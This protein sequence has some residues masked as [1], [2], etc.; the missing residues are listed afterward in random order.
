MGDERPTGATPGTGSR[1]RV[2]GAA[3]REPPAEALRERQLGQLVAATRQASGH[4]GVIPQPLPARRTVATATASLLAGLPLAT[5]GLATAGVSLPQP[6]VSAFRAVGIELPNQAQDGDR[7]R[8]VRGGERRDRSRQAGSE[9]TREGAGSP[10][11]G[12]DARPGAMPTPSRGQPSPDGPPAGTPGGKPQGTPGG[13]QQGS[14][15]GVPQGTPSGPPPGIQS[16]PPQGAPSGPPPGLPGAPG[17]RSGVDGTAPQ[18][19]TDS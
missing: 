13:P 10:A 6:A 2:I 11:A 19:G 9:R 8:E 7:E 1:L 4:R 17:Q 12:G 5:A 3:L 16:G 18:A 14:S 15:G